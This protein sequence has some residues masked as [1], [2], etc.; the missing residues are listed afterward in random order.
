M[1]TVPFLDNSLGIGFL[2]CL[3]ILGARRSDAQQ[4]RALRVGIPPIVTPASPAAKQLTDSVADQRGSRLAH[5]AVGMAA[6][7]V[8]GGILGGV[9]A[10]SSKNT[11]TALDGI[12][13]AT[14]VIA[15]ALVGAV[16]GG[17]IGAFI[18]HS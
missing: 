11:G 13:A 5:I 15:G 18:P 10:G 8:T 3:L 17:A 4:L 16:V 14:S 7:G 9:S 6:G 2:L 12:A 1:R